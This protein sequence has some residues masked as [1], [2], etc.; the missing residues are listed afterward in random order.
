MYLV[1]AE[2]TE[3]LVP[4]PRCRTYMSLSY[5]DMIYLFTYLVKVFKQFSLTKCV[6]DLSAF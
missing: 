1:H 5:I 2:Y 3:I 6:F 4:G